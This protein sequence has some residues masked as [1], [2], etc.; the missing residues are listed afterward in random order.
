MSLPAKVTALLIAAALAVVVGVQFLWLVKPAAAREVEAACKGLAPS[1]RSK[2]LRRIPG[3]APEFTVVDRQGNKVH[4]AD[5]RGKVV[6][7][8]FWAS[9]CTTCKAEKP[10]LELL[11][12]ELGGDDFVILSLSSDSGWAS[13]DKKYPDGLDVD[14]MLD[15]TAEE[16]GEI[17]PVARAWGVEAVPE[18]FAIDRRGNLRYYFVN[19]RDWNSDVAVTC[20]R[21][22][23]DE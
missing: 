7:V 1:P 22:L 16:E 18:S 21:G 9:W 15:K 17:G 8:N 13:I 19:K 20:L 23:I 12:Q 10:T 4:L 2:T 5:Y 6:L 14:V 11:N 3:P